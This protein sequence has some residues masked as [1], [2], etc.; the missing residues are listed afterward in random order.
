MVLTEVND[1][2]TAKDFIRV[3]VEMNAGN[4]CY[5]RPLDKE[6][7]DVFNPEKN[8]QFRHGEAK[9]W[10]I[11]GDDGKL[12]G[13]IAAFVNQ[14]YV[15]RGTDYPVGGIGFFDCVNDQAVAN[16]LFD[17]A[18]EWL[19]SRGMEAMDGPVNFG[20]RDKWWGLLV[21]GFEKEP[22]YG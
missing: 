16:R 18:A 12:K 6:I 21:E 4:R 8:K 15:N 1:S 14:K 13:R 5:I 11:S 9:R 7:Y 2:A 20:D 3:N 19:K 10:I 17:T 22:I